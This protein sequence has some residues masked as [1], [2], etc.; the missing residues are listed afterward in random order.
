MGA[1]ARQP[2]VKI[3]GST[4]RV[5][6]VAA[7]AA[8]RDASGVA[9]KLDEESRP[10]VKASSEWIRPRPAPRCDVL[11]VGAQMP[12]LHPISSGSMSRGAR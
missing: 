11:S 10:R 4:L 12:R 3:E 9:V 7:V 6:Q 5:G 1:Q 2:V 8:A